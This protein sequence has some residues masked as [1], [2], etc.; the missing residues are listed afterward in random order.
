M[1]PEPFDLRAV[2]EDVS[3]LLNLRVQE[4]GLELLV[5]YQP[6]LGEKFIGDAGRLRQVVTNLLG[7]AVKFTETGHV[8][9]AVSG[10]RLGETAA[11][12]IAVSDTGCGIPREKL[13]AVFEKFE[14]ADN[15]AARRFDGAGLGLAISRRIA[16][17]MGGEISVESEIGVGSTFKVALSLRIDEN[18]Q[19]PLERGRNLFADIRAL[20]VDDNA[21]NRAIL[22]EQLAS[23]GIAATTAS[24]AHEALACARE[25]AAA[26]AGFHIAILDG[27]MPGM[28]GMDLARALRADAALAGLP[29]VLLTSGGR[30]GDP[31]PEIGELF[32]AYLVK[33]ARAS[34]LLDS[35]G[36]CLSRGAADALVETSDL[37]AKC[38]RRQETLRCAL[39]PDGRPLDVLVAEDNVVNQMV[40][41]AMLEKLGCRTRIADNGRK[42]VEEYAREEPDVVLMDISMPDM[43]GVEATAAIRALQAK[44]GRTRPIIG[45]TA[46]ALRED[47]QRCIDAAMDDYLPKPIKQAALEETLTRWV[48][49]ASPLA[50]SR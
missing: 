15:S 8:S 43:D 35:I 21:V 26:G 42:A 20:A 41:R 32:D 12:V 3:S 13:S 37:L 33:P 38:D 49:A 31:E 36:A 16:Q 23:W 22:S 28:S 14:Q 5:R 50:I 40:V 47:R 4:K 27:Q 29:L 2:I 39:T 1:T 19:A 6:D 18:A 44:K 30:K 17:A 25:A 11:V 7:N 48:G 9:V 46:H 24:N 45:V 10:R 34:M